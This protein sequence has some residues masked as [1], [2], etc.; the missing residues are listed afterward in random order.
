MSVVAFFFIRSNTFLI[1]GRIDGMWSSTCRALHIVSFSHLIFIIARL[2]FFIVN[3]T[4][5]I[6]CYRL[7]MVAGETI[8]M[9]RNN[10]HLLLSYFSFLRA[11][12]H[13][14]GYFLLIVQIC[15]TASSLNLVLLHKFFTF[16]ALFSLY[17]SIF[18]L[19]AAC[20][21]LKS[22]SDFLYF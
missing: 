16:C 9:C 4:I 2:L 18:L 10:F 14:R 13:E 11:S 5:F 6:F 21:T 8:R 1:G 7:A 12:A 20:S 17:L 15:S 22:A 3:V 19:K